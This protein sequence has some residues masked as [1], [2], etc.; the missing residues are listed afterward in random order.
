MNK[1]MSTIHPLR[2]Y[3]ER[4]NPPLDRTQLAKMLG[5]TAASV[6]RWESGKRR[7]DETIV[8]AISEKTGIPV[9]DLRPDLSRLLEIERV[10][11]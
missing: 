9:A 4:H 6:S 1:D 8:S 3:R 11:S 2:A 5:V 10:A 7:L